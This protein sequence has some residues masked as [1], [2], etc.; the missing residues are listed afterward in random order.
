MVSPAASCPSAL[1]GSAPRRDAP[2]QTEEEGKGWGSEV[3]SQDP[4]S[5]Q[6]VLLPTAACLRRC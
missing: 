6:S 1:P 3:G 5:E 4:R 2:E